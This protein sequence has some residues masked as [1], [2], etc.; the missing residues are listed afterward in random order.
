M[1]LR[2]RASS[3]RA[4]QLTSP[5]S[6]GDTSIPLT[7]P[8]SPAAH[9]IPHPITSLANHSLSD[10]TTFIIDYRHIHYRYHS[11]TEPL[12]KANFWER[13]NV[14]VVEK[15]IQESIIYELYGLPRE[16]RGCCGEVTAHSG[17]STV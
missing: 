13:K 3:A 7:L 8:S 15:F 2:R 4:P 16:L 17:S 9:P 14:A 1:V 11:T 6:R 10:T 12:L 5:P